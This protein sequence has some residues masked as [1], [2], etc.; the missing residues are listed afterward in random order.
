MTAMVAGR[1]QGGRS[2]SVFGEKKE[3]YAGPMGFRF[4]V[5]YLNREAGRIRC[6]AVGFGW[7]AGVER[8]S[9]FHCIL[10]IWILPVPVRDSR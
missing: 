2:L 1:L 4:Q 3:F 8:G 9:L 6:G 5:D 7:L 10:F